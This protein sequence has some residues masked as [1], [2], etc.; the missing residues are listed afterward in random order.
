MPIKQSV[1]HTFMACTPDG[2]KVIGEVPFTELD[3]IS[4]YRLLQ[5]EPISSGAV[6]IRIDLDDSARFFEWWLEWQFQQVVPKISR[7]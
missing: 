7:K 6:S 1:K 5:V 4:A 2:W 3:D